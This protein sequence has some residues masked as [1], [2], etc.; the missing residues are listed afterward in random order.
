MLKEEYLRELATKKQTS[1]DNILR[2]Y[3]QNVFLN[4]LYK[5]SG[6]KKMLFKG[7]TALRLA[8]GSPRF[9]EDLDFTLNDITFNEVENTILAV[10][11]DLEKEGFLPKIVESKKTSGGYLAE[12]IVEIG[13]EKVRISIQGSQRKKGKT[14]PEIKL[15]VNDFVPDYSA[16]LLEERELI[17]EKISAALTRAKPRDFFDV[18][19]LLRGGHIPVELREK[20]FKIPDVIENK[21]INFSKDI[22]HLLPHGMQD[23]VRSFPKPLLNE[24]GK[25]R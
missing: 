13:N 8:F 19:Y 3:A 24:I 7:G 21:N 11:N 1:F 12:L 9:S 4:L 15:I 14:K 23:L 20:L 2:E 17:N 25:F 5:E 6:G 18:Y 10:L 22:T 16:Y